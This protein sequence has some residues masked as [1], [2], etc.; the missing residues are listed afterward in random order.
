[1]RAQ[2]IQPAAQN[3]M[4][5]RRIVSTTM[6]SRERA[7]RNHWLKR[8]I[9]LMLLATVLSIGHVWSRMQVLNA[10]YAITAVQ[11]RIER[12]SKMVMRV[13]S[14]VSALQSAERLTRLARDELKMTAPAAGQVVVVRAPERAV[15]VVTP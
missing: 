15:E 6:G 9:G 7:L 14:M 2:R 10:R 5:A 13:E 11:Q 4:P 12:L 1:M 8:I 3:P